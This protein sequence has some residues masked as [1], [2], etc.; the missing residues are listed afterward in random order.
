MK[1]ILVCIIFIGKLSAQKN[2]Y[3][4]STRCQK[5]NSNFIVGIFQV[6][7]NLNNNFSQ[8]SFSETAVANNNY[9]AESKE[10]TGIE[11]NYDKFS[12]G[13]AISSKPQK[14]N[15]AKGP[16]KAIGIN[17]NFGGNIWQIENNFRSFKGFYDKNTSAYDSSGAYNYQANYSNLLFRSKFMYFTNHRRY[18][19]KSNYAC[20]YRQLRTSAS[21]IF[22]AN[23]H[24]NFIYNDSSFFAPASRPYYGDYANMNSLSVFGISMNAGAAVTIVFWRAF[25]AHVM[26]MV[27]PEQQWRTYGY[28]GEGTS[29]LAYLSLSGDLRGSIGVNFKRFY[30]IFFSRNEFAL[31][32]NS[33]VNLTGR[34][35]SGGMLI[36]WRFKSHTPEFYK[37][38]Q[39]SKLYSL[40]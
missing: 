4:D 30:W 31:Y 39:S 18:S 12:F 28:F 19:F 13:I 29:K 34:S 35:L 11:V 17:L 25:F 2:P 5:F 14:S 10:I 3:W 8:P 23:T 7:N 37:K 15:V 9:L 32:N 22:S 33:F 24:Y 6:H 40:F 27:G 21:W 36:G 26:F 1:Y 16:S 38:F 20:N